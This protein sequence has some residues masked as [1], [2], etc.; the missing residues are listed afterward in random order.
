MAKKSCNIF[1][2]HIYN[3]RKEEFWASVCKEF[4]IEATGE[5]FSMRQYESKVLQEGDYKPEK[6][7]TGEPARLRSFITQ[8]PPFDVKNPYMAPIRVNRGLHSDKSDRH[9]MHIEIDIK[10]SRIR[11]DAGDHV[12]VYPTN[13]P[14]LVSRLGELLGIDLDTVFTMIN[15]DEDSTKKHPFPCPVKK[16]Y[17]L[18]CYCH[19]S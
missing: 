1:I 16:Y 10:D 9:C 7:Y 18:T 8:R 2:C 15:L 19:V 5:E 13:D 12:A 17:I 11:Y 14:A 4:N 3:C 6:L